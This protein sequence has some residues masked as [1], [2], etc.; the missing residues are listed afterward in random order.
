MNNYAVSMNRPWLHIARVCPYSAGRLGHAGNMIDISDT[1]KR[2]A[3][4]RIRLD[5]LRLLFS[6]AMVEFTLLEDSVS[7]KVEVSS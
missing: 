7:I 2:L 6:L 3:A 4:A 1:W 5:K